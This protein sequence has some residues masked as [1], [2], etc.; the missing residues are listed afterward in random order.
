MTIFAFILL[1]SCFGQKWYVSIQPT[2]IWWLKICTINKYCWFELLFIFSFVFF[3][4]VQI[5]FFQPTAGV[6]SLWCRGIS[7]HSAGHTEVSQRVKETRSSEHRE[8][9]SRCSFRIS[10][11][12]VYSLCGSQATFSST[13]SI[14]QIKSSAS[15]KKDVQMIFSQIH[16]HRLLV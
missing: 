11:C 13:P 15:L 2:C 14:M 3:S 16:M 8:W 7:K 12:D 6:C 1:S 5:L 9:H 4:C 10:F